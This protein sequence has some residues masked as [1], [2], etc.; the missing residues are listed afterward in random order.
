MLVGG[1]CGV[2]VMRDHHK[3]RVFARAR[4]L[5]VEIYRVT[6]FVRF[7]EIALGS[8]RELECQLSLT[9]E[10]G[11]ARLDLAPAASLCSDT[12]RML[13]ALLR[14]H[15]ASPAPTPRALWPS[16]LSPWP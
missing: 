13:V 4:Q 1:R 9:Q 15:P 16:A 5:V 10:L 14:I 6:E 8:T 11:L 12:A 7:I 3:L 2:G